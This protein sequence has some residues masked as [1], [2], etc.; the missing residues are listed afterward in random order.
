MKLSIRTFILLCFVTG[1]LA[2][3]VTA[4]STFATPSTLPPMEMPEPVDAFSINQRL[5]RGVNL[6]NALEG[7]PDEGAWGM[8]IQEDYFDLIKDAGFDSV[9]IPIRW[10]AHADEEAPYTI[11]QDFF[12]R[13]DEVTKWALARDLAVV[14]N[15]HHYDEIFHDPDGYEEG[16]LAMWAQVAQH[17]QET[18]SQLVFEILNEP[19]DELTLTRWNEM[20]VKALTTIRETNPDRV[21]MIGPGEWNGIYALEGLELPEDDQNIIVTVHYYLPF[22]FTH[23]GAEWAEGSEVWLGTTWKGTAGQRAMLRA[24]F[25]TAAQWAD[26]HN[27]PIYLGEFGAYDKADLESRAIWT[28]AVARTA[29][30]FGF[31]WGYWEF[32]AGFGVYD[33]NTISW[34]EPILKALLPSD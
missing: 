2:A 29:E 28:D 24:D 17:Y 20:L 9:R 12:A 18:P 6:G 32:G 3:S 4:C 26:E 5:G 13:V 27:R 30:E 19:H 34:N 8:I 23:Q 33:R 1:F 25:N 31:S 16:L 15:F 11:D 14:I 10:N 21:V 7:Y 22:E